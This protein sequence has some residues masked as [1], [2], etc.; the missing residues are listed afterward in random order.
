MD[1]DQ[2]GVMASA[3]VRPIA[4]V[5]VKL[6]QEIEELDKQIVL[7][8]EQFRSVLQDALVAIK[9]RISAMRAHSGV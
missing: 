5:M 7:S 2:V 6:R 9:Q 3:E 8:S 4:Q 1:H